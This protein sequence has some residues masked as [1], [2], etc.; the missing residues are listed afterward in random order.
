MKLSII[1]INKNN[2]A[3]LK[4]TIQSVVDQTF[5]DFEYIII[6]GN[7]DDASIEIIKRHTDK[8]TYWISEPDNGIYNAMNKGIAKAQGNYCLFLN[9][10]DWLIEP[11]TLKNVFDEIDSSSEA[12]IYYSNC[13]NTNHEYFTPPKSIDVNFLLTRGINHQNALIKRSLF[14]NHGAYNEKFRIA[15]DFEFW[16]KE[17]WLYKTNFSYIN[18]DIAICDALGIS[19]NSKFDSEIEDSYRNVFDSLADSLIILRRYRCGTYGRI[20]ET[21]GESKMLEFA[22][23][24]YKYVC[25]IFYQLGF[26]K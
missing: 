2:A 5:D 9:S 6:D 10:G 25:K 22:L 19:S 14:V 24:C 11:V 3:G 21:F 8:I 17:Y 20:I 4:K 26:H 7:S 23:K 13:M 16:L 1:T 15:S 18:T 12:D